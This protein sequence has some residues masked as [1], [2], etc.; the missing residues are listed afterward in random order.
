MGLD[1]YLKANL[2]CAGGY[3]H[4]RDE[5]KQMFHD[6]LRV[7]GIEPEKAEK[8]I[9]VSVTIGYWR[10]ANAIHEWFVEH[11]QDGEDDCRDAYVSREKLE[12]LKATCQRVLSEA[13]LKKG[14]I[15]VATGWSA[16]RGEY[17]DYRDGDVIKNTATIEGILPTKSGFFFGGTDYNECYL[18]D[19]Q[20]TIKIM[21][22]ALSLPEEKWSF[23]YHSSW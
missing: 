9:E 18:Q 8:S 6:L 10:K 4:S 19:V 11:C 12:E 14:K 1:M 15:L 20:D 21:D 13:K 2:F 17:K 3:D 22:N 5:E 23:C 16:E 7:V